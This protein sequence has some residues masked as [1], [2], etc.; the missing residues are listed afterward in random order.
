MML[1]FPIG[2]QMIVRVLAIVANRRLVVGVRAC[3]RYMTRIGRVGRSI[4]FPLPAMGCDESDVSARAEMEAWAE[5]G[6]QGSQERVQQSAWRRR[7]AT[8]L[9]LTG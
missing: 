7:G 9:A 2:I 5:G 4:D 3:V 8:R 6:E 1:G